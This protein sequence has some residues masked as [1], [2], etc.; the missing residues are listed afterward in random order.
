[1]SCSECSRVYTRRDCLL[2]HLRTKHRLPPDQALE[3]SQ[4]TFVFIRHSFIG[5]KYSYRSWKK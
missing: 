2:R 3:V 1:M 4:A 5:F